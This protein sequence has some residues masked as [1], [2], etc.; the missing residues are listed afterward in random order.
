MALNDNVPS[1]TQHSECDLEPTQS[2]GLS[3]SQDYEHLYNKLLLEHEKLLTITKSGVDYKKINENLR[4]QVRD[5]EKNLK[6]ANLLLK[7]TEKNN[8]RQIQLLSKNKTQDINIQARKYL[9]SIFS[10]NQL[11]LIMKKKQRVHWSRDEISKAFSLRYFSKRAY[12]YVKDELKYPL[13]GK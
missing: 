8:A 7:N 4:F 5:L 11:D 9:S 13:P 6:V 12:V 2:L 3:Q 1:S 10:K